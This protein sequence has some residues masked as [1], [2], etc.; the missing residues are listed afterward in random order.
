MRLISIVTTVNFNLT[1]A[2]GSVQRGIYRV[3]GYKFRLRT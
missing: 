1:T 3:Y 2:V